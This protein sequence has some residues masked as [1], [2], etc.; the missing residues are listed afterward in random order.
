MDDKDTKELAWWREFAARVVQDS[1]LPPVGSSMICNRY[2]I[3]D[4]RE[5]FAG[6]LSWSCEGEFKQ[7][8]AMQPGI[9]HCGRRKNRHYR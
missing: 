9:C 8:M 2:R 1:A 5:E 7:T 4:T 6:P 3:I